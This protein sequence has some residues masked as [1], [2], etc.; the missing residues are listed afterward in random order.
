MATNATYA[1]GKPF[2][3][4]GFVEKLVFLFKLVI[5]LVTFGF[6]FPRVLSD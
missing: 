3:K 6:A 5:F 2:S 4:M 1:E